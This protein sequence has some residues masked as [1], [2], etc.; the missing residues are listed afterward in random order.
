MI[1]NEWWEVEHRTNLTPSSCATSSRRSTTSCQRELPVHPANWPKSSCGKLQFWRFSLTAES[2]GSKSGLFCSRFESRS[3]ASLV[4]TGWYWCPAS[5]RET[6]NGTR[7]VS[8][9]PAASVAGRGCGCIS[10]AIGGHYPSC[11]TGKCTLTARSRLSGNERSGGSVHRGALPRS[12]RPRSD[13]DWA[14]SIALV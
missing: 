5:G 3:G 8:A 2:A 1:E 10:G 14:L 7:D 6:G 4:S 9:C 11:R 13:I 12:S